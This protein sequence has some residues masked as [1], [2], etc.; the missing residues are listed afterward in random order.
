VTCSSEISVDF[1]RFTRTWRYILE[2]RALHI[3]PKCIPC[4]LVYQIGVEA[5][6]VDIKVY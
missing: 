3:F 1:R 5:N 2:D 4:D 6:L